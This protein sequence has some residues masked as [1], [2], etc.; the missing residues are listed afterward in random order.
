M[1]TNYQMTYDSVP[2]IN[3]IIAGTYSVPDDTSLAAMTRN[4]DHIE[5]KLA[6]PIYSEDFTNEQ[7]QILQEAV[8]DGK[9]WL[10]AQA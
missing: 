9:A 4:V 6:D 2:V 7:K 10:A 5:L 3:E 8:I 1:L